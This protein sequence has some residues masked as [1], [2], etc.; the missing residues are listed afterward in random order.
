MA[1]CNSVDD[2]ARALASPTLSRRKGIKAAIAALAGGLLRLSSCANTLL[3]GSNWSCTT[4]GNK[5]CCPSGYDY[6]CDGSCYQGGCPA[7]TTTIGRC[8]G[9]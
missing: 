1:N 4:G 6:M 7:G 5:D 3:C 2:A 8:S 9:N